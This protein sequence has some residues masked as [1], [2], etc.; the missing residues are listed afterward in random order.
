METLFFEAPLKFRTWLEKNHQIEKEVWV[1]FYKKASKKPSMTWS[2]SVDQALCFG[3]ID[4]IRKS[5]D[6]VS[7][8]IR[9]T[10]RKAHS[11]WSQ[12]NIQKIEELKKL[13]LLMPAGLAA[14]EKRKES[15]AR[16][17]S[18]E[19]KDDIELIPEYIAQIKTQEKAWHF[20]E[21]QLSPYY[22]KT[23]IYWIMSAKRKSTQL[24]RLK[25]L[26]ESSNQGLKIPLLRK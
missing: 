17:Y 2:E 24:K 11:T 26:I 14:F 20:F 10:P 21:N 22:K 1:G 19:Q 23:S 6:E 15:N 9:F 3:W 7:Y 13:A 5:I 18:Y 4:G 16:S 12:V 25:I 8:K